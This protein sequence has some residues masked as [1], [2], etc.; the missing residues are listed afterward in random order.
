[1]RQCIYNY[2]LVVKHS[3]C[4]MSMKGYTHTRTHART[5]AH[6]QTHNTQH[7]TQW[8][9]H[10]PTQ[11]HPRHYS[12]CT[13][14]TL[15]V[16]K[17]SSTP[18]LSLSSITSEKRLLISLVQSNRAWAVARNALQRPVRSSAESKHIIIQWELCCWN[19][20]ARQRLLVVCGWAIS[21]RLESYK[22]AYVLVITPLGRK[23][24]IC[25]HDK[26]GH[27]APNWECLSVS[28]NLTGGAVTIDLF[29]TRCR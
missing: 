11:R 25:R 10:S 18:K 4:S 12:T 3:A 15:H 26:Q 16:V 7:N 6:T 21:L 1:M 20:S 14:R 2:T 24:L 19:H 28:H 9:R 13:V 22:F 5:H 8:E 17:W 27:E 23:W 29:P